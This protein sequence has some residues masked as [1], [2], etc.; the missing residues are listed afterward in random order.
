M[1]DHI[2]EILCTNGFTYLKC[3]DQMEGPAYLP[4]CNPI[5][6]IWNARQVT[7]RQVPPWSFRTVNIAN[8]E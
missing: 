2:V 1:L 5:E 3:I 4:E 7:A 8:E 6:H